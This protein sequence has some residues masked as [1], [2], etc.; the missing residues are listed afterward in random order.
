MEE[1]RVLTQEEICLLLEESS[2]CFL[3]TFGV[4]RLRKLSAEG[5][6]SVCSALSQQC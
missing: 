2:L 3:S 6:H 5:Y 4:F 1:N